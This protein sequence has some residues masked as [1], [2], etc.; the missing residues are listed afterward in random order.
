MS[1]VFFPFVEILSPLLLCMLQARVGNHQ[2][3]F[4][5]GL[6]CKVPQLYTIISASSQPTPKGVFALHKGKGR[7]KQ[8]RQA[9]VFYPALRNFFLIFF[10]P[11]FLQWINSL[12]VVHVENHLTDMVDGVTW[13][14]CVYLFF[15]F[16]F[17]KKCWEGS[18]SDACLCS[19][20]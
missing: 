9:R 19:A 14:K 1:S 6:V 5:C 7:P 15:F 2:S 4:H 18:N 13:A 12:G 8:T 16:G 3:C 11:V 17:G 10:L 20:F